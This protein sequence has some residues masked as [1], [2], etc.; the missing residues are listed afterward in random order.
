MAEPL[1]VTCLSLVCPV[2]FTPESAAAAM[3]AGIDAFTEL[4]Y[5]DNAG[6]PIIGA[7]VPGL[8]Q[9]LRGRARV[10]GLLARAFEVIES[11]LPGGLTSTQLPLILCTREPERPGAKLNSIVGE[12]EARLGL[13]FRRD[14]SMHVARG[15]VSAF[16]ALTHARRILYE[17][18]T[19]ACLIVAGDT[20]VDARTLLWL[21]QAKRLKTSEQTDG[22]IPG[23]AAC[24]VLVT[25]RSMTRSQ[26]AVRGLGFGEETATVLNEE[27]LLGKGMAAAG[28]AALDE[29]GLAMHEVAFRL[30]DV[31]GESYAFEELVLAQS[32]LMRKT[33]ETQD[34]WHPAGFVGDCGAA[35][36]LVQFAWAEQAFARSYAPGAVA[37][38][39]G[40]AAAG[41]RAAAVVGA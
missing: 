26:L 12:V 20:L 6:E 1:Y 16:E 41:A 23:E 7:V 22:V 27:P 17:A 3:R 32:R 29:A 18:R 34:L 15:P 35:A 9:D 24:V 14:G 37:L 19:E 28:K 30:S 39:H 25:K 4:P 38:A 40:S 5:A 31:A 2:G 33:R 8:P 21:D 11:R 10:I 36:G 13:T